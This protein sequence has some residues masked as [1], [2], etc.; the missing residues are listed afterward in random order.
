MSTA[1]K[2]TIYYRRIPVADDEFRAH[3]GLTMCGGHAVL[4][5]QSLDVE[6]AD[7][8]GA[9]DAGWRQPSIV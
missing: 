9:R 4:D 5:I 2:Q 6:A 7:M 8:I 3:F 1:L